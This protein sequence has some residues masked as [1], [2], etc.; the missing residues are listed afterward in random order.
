MNLFERNL[1]IEW[2]VCACLCTAYSCNLHG[3]VPRPSLCS[4]EAMRCM[5][6]PNT[7]VKQVR[8]E[9]LMRGAP[10]GP[11]AGPITTLTSLGQLPGSA[12]LPC[13]QPVAHRAACLAPGA[14]A[15]TAAGCSAT[16]FFRGSWSGAI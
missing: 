14:P 6:I 2:Q 16:T 8:R 7:V 4:R 10:F 12:E 15:S 3:L 9:E 11:I 5:L 1:S 13:A